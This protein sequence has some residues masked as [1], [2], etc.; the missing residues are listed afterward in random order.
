MA[1]VVAL[2]SFVGVLD[3]DVLNEPRV[4]KTSLGTDTFPGTVKTPGKSIQVVRGQAFE[5]NHPAVKKWP[6]LFGRPELVHGPVEQATAA[7]G[8]KRGAR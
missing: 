8:E 1:T 3:N 4:V 7:P 6:A 5:D 2:T